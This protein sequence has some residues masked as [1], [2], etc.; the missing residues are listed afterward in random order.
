MSEKWE[1]RVTTRHYANLFFDES[2]EKKRPESLMAIPK[3]W[4]W[5]QRA[6]QVI[7][8][9]MDY[10]I[11]AIELPGVTEESHE[12]VIDNANRNGCTFETVEC[13]NLAR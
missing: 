4:F 3:Q 13:V 2:G 12:S 8:F 9:L 5:R 11:S 7:D 6:A 1:S 10:R